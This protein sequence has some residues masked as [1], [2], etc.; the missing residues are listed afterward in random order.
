M[1]MG[2]CAANSFINDFI[3]SPEMPKRFAIQ[4]VNTQSQTQRT[5]HLE[6]KVYDKEKE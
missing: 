6:L 1:Q 4:N 3:C 5:C 2:G